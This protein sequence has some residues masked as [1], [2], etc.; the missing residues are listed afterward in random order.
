METINQNCVIGIVLTLI[1]MYHSKRSPSPC[2]EYYISINFPQS[3]SNFPFYSHKTELLIF[4]SG[5]ERL[6]N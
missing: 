5:I 3:L 4:E 1:E 2:S 6:E